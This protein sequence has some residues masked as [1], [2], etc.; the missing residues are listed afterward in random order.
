M[1]FLNALVVLDE[2]VNL[3]LDWQQEFSYITFNTLYDLFVMWIN[4]LEKILNFR[5]FW[6]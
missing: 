6:L 3:M 2:K 1:F 4:F 5:D